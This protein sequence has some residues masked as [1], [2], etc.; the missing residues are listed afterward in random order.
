[1]V[2]PVIMYLFHAKKVYHRSEALYHRSNRVY[3]RLAGVYHRS[4]N[5]LNKKQPSIIDGCQNFY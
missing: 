4:T 2:F 5:I 1:M 3:H